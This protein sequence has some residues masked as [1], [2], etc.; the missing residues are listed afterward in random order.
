[1]RYGYDGETDRIILEPNAEDFDVCNESGM[2]VSMT[3]AE[4]YEIYANI[5]KIR[6]EYIIKNHKGFDPKYKITNL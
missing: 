6:S 3:F 4:L 5:M 1:M 2:K